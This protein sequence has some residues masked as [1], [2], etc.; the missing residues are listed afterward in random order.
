[1]IAVVEKSRRC[2][3]DEVV[4]IYF[5]FQ[6]CKCHYIIIFELLYY[7][8]KWHIISY[9]TIFLIYILHNKSKSDTRTIKYINDGYQVR[10]LFHAVQFKNNTRR[11]T[12]H[13]DPSCKL[14]TQNL[15]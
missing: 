4:G 2:E 9:K 5:L 10:T 12:F 7:K 3:K 13:H 8:H 15:C 14:R 6:S 11:D 1:M